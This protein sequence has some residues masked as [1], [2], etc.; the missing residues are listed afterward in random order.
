MHF[1]PKYM[2]LFIL[3]SKMSITAKVS[4][5][6]RI[7]GLLLA[8]MIPLILFALHC[9]LTNADFYQLLHNSLLLKIIYFIILW[10]FVYHACS[11]VRFLFIDLHKGVEITVAKKTAW[12]VIISSCIVTFLISII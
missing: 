6:H 3:G 10:M 11:G 7:S 4:I 1:R 5:L 9:S 2:N 12:G 8:A